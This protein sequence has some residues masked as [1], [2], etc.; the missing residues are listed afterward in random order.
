MKINN[1]LVVYANPK[2]K[3]EESALECVK[4]T[5]KKHKINYKI[6]HRGKP[7]KKLFQNKEL[8]IV[9][10]GDGTFLQTSH[11]IFDKTPVIGV[12]SD[13]RYKEGFF[14]AANKNDFEIKFKRMLNMGYKTI[15]LKRLEAYVGR[16]KVPELALN[17]FYIASEKPYHTARYFFSAKGKREM[18][19]SSGILISTA[20][21]S[22]AWIKSAGGEVLPLDTDKFEYL[23][24]EPYCGRVS[25]KYK[26]IN[27]ILNKNEK[28]EITFEFGNGILIADSLS[29]EYR[30]KAGQK[31]TVKISKKPLYYV[32]FN[33]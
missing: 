8:V 6:A 23:I 29:R 15:K 5:L 24:R 22:N 4:T 14:M 28:A 19:K 13:P 11:F 7:N 9:V 33:V 12:N 31:V 17:E 26:L 32:S 20:A 30:F 18:Q 1:I 2:N 10:G 27:G 25:A 16:K 3:E 21:G